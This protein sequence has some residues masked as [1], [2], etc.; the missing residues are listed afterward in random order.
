MRQEIDDLMDSTKIVSREVDM[1]EDTNQ[2]SK[3]D[4]YGDMQKQL[5]LKFNKGPADHPVSGY[6]L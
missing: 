5:S 3:K 1:V 4:K 2:S 6:L